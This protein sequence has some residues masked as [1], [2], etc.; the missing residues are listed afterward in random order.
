MSRN[1]KDEITRIARN[2]FAR[3]GYDGVSTRMLADEAGIS[4]ATLNY[5][6]GSKAALYEAVFRDAFV[7]EEALIIQFCAG[8]EDRTVA[9]PVALR[10]ALCDLVADHITL[11]NRYQEAPR[12]WLQR[13]LA[14][15]DAAIARIDVDFGRGL[16]RAVRD[17][18][19]R[20]QRAG[21]V[22]DDL[23]M[24]HFLLSVTWM[25]YGFFSGGSLGTV[26][27]SG[28][29]TP[30]ADDLAQFTAHLQ[31]YVC[32]MLGLPERSMAPTSRRGTGPR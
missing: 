8:I 30:T 22:A 31:R 14:E 12:L 24:R 1:T 25:E 7:H 6:I 19:V 27:R 13:W 4:V 9:E 17:V 15:P 26:G 32:R 3:Y 11:L 28:P 16:Y 20:A 29:L 21:T 5:H 10:E 2:L 18:L 23:D